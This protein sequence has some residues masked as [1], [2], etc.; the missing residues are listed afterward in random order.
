MSKLFEIKQRIQHLLNEP[1]DDKEFVEWMKSYVV[2][3]QEVL[4]PTSATI[5]EEQRKTILRNM[6]Q[7][8]LDQRVVDW[9]AKNKVL[10]AHNEYWWWLNDDERP[11]HFHGLPETRGIPRITNGIDVW[12][13][14]FS[15]KLFKGHRDN[16]VYERRSRKATNGN[17]SS[18]KPT[19]PLCTITSR[20]IEIAQTL[21]DKG[22]DLFKEKYRILMGHELPAEALNMSVLPQ[23]VHQYLDKQITDSLLNT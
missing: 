6:K 5:T 4:H 20:D 9:S 10:L 11:A 2:R 13:E 21:L 7:F 18:A 19:E 1:H 3:A 12:S 8:Q 14:L 17:G 23:H 16:L 15:G 22:C